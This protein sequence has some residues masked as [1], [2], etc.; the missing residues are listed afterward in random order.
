M[1]KIGKT[2]QIDFSHIKTADQFY[3]ELSNL[4]GFPGFFGRN[5]NALIDCLFSLRYPHD[6]MTKIHIT[7]SEY[8]LMELNYFSSAPDEIKELLMIAIENVSL[9]CREKNQKSSIVLLL[10]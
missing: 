8:L 1:M 5:V 6:E 4:F 3:T 9:K 7:T 10:N 2:V